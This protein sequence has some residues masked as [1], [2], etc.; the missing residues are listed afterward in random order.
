MP[1]LGNICAKSRAYLTGWVITRRV[2]LL[3]MKEGGPLH[4][5]CS[6]FVRLAR[7]CRYDATG[8]GSRSRSLRI[9]RIGGPATVAASP[10]SLNV[11]G[12][13][14]TVVAELHRPEWFVGVMTMRST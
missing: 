5:G 13:M 3:K 10:S 7:S 4:F 8:Y 14:S 11:S 12:T 2:E 9:P 6:T 1:V